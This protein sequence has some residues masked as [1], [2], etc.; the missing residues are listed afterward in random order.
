[1]KTINLDKVPL[2]PIQEHTS[3]GDQPKWRLQGKWYKADHMGYEALC[4]VLISRLLSKSNVNKYVRY[5]PVNI[6]WD[7]KILLGCESSN[8]R[9]KDEMLIPFER[10]HRAY[11]GLGLAH[12][13]ARM[14]TPAERLVYTVDFVQSVT[15]LENVGAYLTALIE[16]D[17]LFLNEDRHTNNL[18]VIR[19]ETTGQFRLC[20]VFDNGMSLLSDLNAY[21]MGAD[22][23]ECI[24]RV[25]AKPFAVDFAEQLAA[26]EGSFGPQIHFRFTKQ[27]VADVLDELQKLY[28][29]T[30]CKRVQQCLYEQMRRYPILF[31]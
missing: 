3:K 29:K 9:A 2:E 22:I 8:F 12:A 18:A 10:L 17:A 1:M 15:G 30:V 13:L 19:N 21:P 28:S 31:A 5:E 4:E 23:C 16:M 24:D 20:P 25:R 6:I 11:K 7:N 14:E 26:A 27:D